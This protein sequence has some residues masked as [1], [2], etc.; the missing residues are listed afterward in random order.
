MSIID[1]VED[2]IKIIGKMNVLDELALSIV[3]L[4]CDESALQ[5]KL[6]VLDLIS[7]KID[8]LKTSKIS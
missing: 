2:T 7:D 5:F 8:E 6:D 3:S 4:P 1:D